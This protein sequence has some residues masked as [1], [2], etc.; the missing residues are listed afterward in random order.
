MEHLVEVVMEWLFARF[1]GKP[2]SMP[3]IEEKETFVVRHKRSVTVAVLAVIGAFVVGC[4]LFFLLLQQEERW[5]G[6]LIGVPAFLAFW[7]PAWLFSFRCT[8]TTESLRR[9]GFG[10][11]KKEVLWS[12]VICVR[13][14]EQTEQDSPSVTIAV[15]DRTRKCVIDVSAE[16]DN[17]WH[18]V[19]MAEKK[20]I[21][22]RRESNLSLKQMNRLDD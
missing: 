3:E 1:K 4:A 19:K 7:V 2:D 8:V 9:S 10:W 21:E 16:M 5:I 20:E 12:D 15:Y 6:V 11:R 22:I 17:A 14:I 18:I 13:V